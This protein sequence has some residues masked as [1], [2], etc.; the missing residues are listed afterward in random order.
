MDNTFIEQ[1]VK[2]E[3]KSKNI[4]IKIGLIV[5]AIVLSIAGLFILKTFFPVVFVV[6]CFGTWF[7]IRRI[8]KMC[9]RDRSIIKT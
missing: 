4:L 8:D 6:I 1:M 7:L 5:L 3:N 9:I 2:Q